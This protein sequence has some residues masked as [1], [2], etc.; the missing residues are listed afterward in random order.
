MGNQCCCHRYNATT[1]QQKPNNKPD[2]KIKSHMNSENVEI[3]DKSSPENTN[4]S[5]RYHERDILKNPPLLITK[6]FE[7]NK[8]IGNN[9]Y[10]VSV[11]AKHKYSNK[12]VIIKQVKPP[13]RREEKENLIEE[14]NKLRKLVKLM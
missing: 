6:V 3:L 11:L 14:I 2:A 8:S 4:V 1:I 13:K 5:I 12:S 7:I 9:P 10:S